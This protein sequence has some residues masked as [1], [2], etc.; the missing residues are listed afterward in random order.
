MR[1]SASHCNSKAT[2]QCGACQQAAYCSSICAKATWNASHQFE[3]IA[4]YDN[5]LREDRRVMRQADQIVKQTMKDNSRAVR[6]FIDNDKFNGEQN[7]EGELFFY[8]NGDEFDY[9]VTSQVTNELKEKIEAEYN[10]LDVTSVQDAKKFVRKLL[11]S[12]FFVDDELQLVLASSIPEREELDFESDSDDWARQA[13]QRM[14]QVQDENDG[15]LPADF[16]GEEGVADPSFDLN[17]DA[18]QLLGKVMKTEKTLYLIWEDSWIKIRYNP[19]TDSFFWDVPRIINKKRKWRNA[20]ASLV[21][22]INLRATIPPGGVRQY[23]Y[24][25]MAPQKSL[26]LLKEIQGSNYIKAYAFSE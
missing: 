26:F 12:Y 14:D 25:E 20:I 1:F 17:V 24:Q 6:M 8:F 18:N 13:K 4:G 2:L 11:R 10:T 22:Q 9:F 15:E 7:K 19:Q 16:G 21:R 3:C 23:L 5:P